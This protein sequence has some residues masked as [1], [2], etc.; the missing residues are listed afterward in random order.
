MP[1]NTKKDKGIVV[2]RAKLAPPQSPNHHPDLVEN[3]AESVD[4]CHRLRIVSLDYD[5]R[6]LQVITQ[7]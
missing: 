6:L 5:L 3:N 2:A 7:V 1:Y 4:T